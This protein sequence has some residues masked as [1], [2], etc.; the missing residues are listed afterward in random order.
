MNLTQPPKNNLIDS[1]RLKYRPQQIKVLFV[2]EAPPENTERFFYYERIT[3][4]D[5]LFI[6][7][8]RVLYPEF[9]DN[10]G[11]SLQ[12]IR[13]HKPEILKRFQQ[14][15]FYL[16]DALPG[17]IS[18]KL[19]SSERARLIRQNKHNTLNE[20][21]RNLSPNTKAV[22]IKATVYDA[23]FNFLT[24]SNILVIN[25]D[26]KVPFPS[27]G[28]ADEFRAKLDLILRENGILT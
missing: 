21:K 5:Y 19:S 8:V 22:L 4:K 25:G 20:I 12:E 18:L 7:L 3:E 2:A 15:G 27:R 23:L 26:N 28:H 9:N 10:N 24:E 11:G 1:A 16:I 17:P 14:D 13:K 6:N